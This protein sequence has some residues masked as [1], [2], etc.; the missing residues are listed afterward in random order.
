MFNSVF[1]KTIFGIIISTTQAWGAS[2]ALLKAQE[3]YLAKDNKTV[4]TSIHQALRG[5]KLSQAEMRN[6]SGLYSRVLAEA[7]QQAD[8]GWT[9]PQQMNKMR[10]MVEYIATD[11]S[12]KNYNLVVTGNL[13]AGSHIKSFIIKKYPDLVIVDKE[14]NIGVFKSESKANNTEDFRG[15]PRN[16]Q[17]LP[18]P[19]GAYLIDFSLDSGEKTSGWFYIAEDMNS[20]A[21][22]EFV[23]L[24][25]GQVITTGTPSFSWKM[26]QSPNR[27]ADEEYQVIFAV[28]PLK[29]DG[30]WGAA[31]F[32]FY[33]NNSK[34]TSMNLATDTPSE[35]AQV[36]LADGNYVASIA[37]NDYKMISPVWMLRSSKIYKKITVKK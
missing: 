16:G 33:Q 14:K 6:L 21:N 8:Y 24:T 3:A 1:K 25:N 22:P 12:N 37:Y 11:D 32:V 31:N 13:K 19:S 23:G 36:P 28:N 26:F 34:V 35:P 18:V 2:P 10:V 30:N 17:A 20:P 29:D 27:K 5:P 4:F 9:L 7:P 15:R